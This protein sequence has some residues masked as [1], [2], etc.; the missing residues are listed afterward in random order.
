MSET[1]T[2][3]DQFL[4]LFVFE[5]NQLLEQ[6][7]KIIINCEKT[8]SFREDDVNEIFRFMHTTKSSAAMMGYLSLSELAH[9]LEDL[10]ALL[11]NNKNRSY[12]FH[13]F[14]TLTL[15]GVDAIK[16]FVSE[17]ENGTQPLESTNKLK[18][19]IG[20]YI[21]ELS[22]VDRLEPK[23]TKSKESMKLDDNTGNLPQYD[24]NVFFNDCGQSENI[25]SHLLAHTLKK[26]TTELITYPKELLKPGNSETIRKHGLHLLFNPSVLLSEIE[27]IVKSTVLLNR[28]TLEETAKIKDLQKRLESTYVQS[29]ASL[30][31]PKNAG[32]SMHS[33]IMAVRV[34]KMDMLFN[35]VGEITIS[36][37]MVTKG[38]D[39]NALRA[40]QFRRESERL[41]KLV[42]N[43]QDIVIEM[44][45][46]PLEHVFQKMNRTI[47]SLADT[48]GKEISLEVYGETTE[49]DKKITEYLTDPL[50]HLIRN[51]ADHGI[52][53]KEERKRLGKPPKGIITLSANRVAGEVWVSV[54]DDGRGIDLQHIYSTAKEK[55]LVTKPFEEHSE[56]ELFSYLL[57][58]GFTTKEKVT[59]LSG[60]GV[61]L[62]VVRENIARISGAVQIESKV[63]M[64]TK[65]TLKIPLTL[66]I[67]G[68]MQVV[69]GKS[70]FSIP[71]NMMKETIIP[72][73]VKIVHHIDGN[74]IVMLRGQC[75]PVIRPEQQL[76]ISGYEAISDGILI[77][78]EGHENSACL[79]VDKIVG[80]GQIV[81]KPLPAYIEKTKG[82]FSSCTVLGDGTISLIIDIK[83]L[84][85][86]F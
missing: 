82:C 50:T 84:L 32:A 44:R 70:V 46:V 56:K 7:E 53:E 63:G 5:T 86:E 9:S 31:Q 64:G 43:L 38:H 76:G 36:E 52:E 59:E 22:S 83:Q 74:E 41:S 30:E 29:M 55:G 19:Q 10:F 75:Y 21:Q 79:F 72:K 20:L 11:R 1:G 68:A 65:I 54:E 17:L 24:L 57:M 73:D 33:D 66:S 60:R 18:E 62:D 26:Y 3:K 34:D 67:M 4:D 6:I 48:L 28:Y 80:Q 85:N 35:L 25:R 49:V 37:A 58:P 81:V 42:K 14:F 77:L 45:M 40:D 13:N 2:G 15:A 69:I 16:S 78:V 27:E 23:V 47:I 61:G 8:K 12:D 51:A 39:L 71:I